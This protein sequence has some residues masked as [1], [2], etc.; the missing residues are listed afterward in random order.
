MIPLS[1]LLGA[2]IL[3]CLGV[4]GCAA[5]ARDDMKV[6]QSAERI[7]GQAGL[8]SHLENRKVGAAQSAERIGGQAG[9]ERYLEQRDVEADQSAERIGGQAGLEAHLPMEEIGADQ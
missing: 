5:S 9:L 6:G 1:K 8:A 7:G 2:G 3:L 4:S